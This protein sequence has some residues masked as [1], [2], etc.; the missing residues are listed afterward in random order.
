MTQGHETALDMLP[1][2]SLARSQPIWCPGMEQPGQDP[3]GAKPRP[4][5]YLLTEK[6]ILLILQ[7]RK[8]RLL[9]LGINQRRRPFIATS[10]LLAQ[11]LAGLLGRGGEG[12]Q[13][14]N[15]ARERPKLAI[16]N[17]NLGDPSLLARIVVLPAPKKRR[18]VT[19][20][21]PLG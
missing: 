6:V 15:L 12:E 9:R 14:G 10:A 2:L 3:P 7:C 11:G 17:A 16:A 20:A 4:P 8:G 21:S 1:W 18:A 5:I 19:C 13:G